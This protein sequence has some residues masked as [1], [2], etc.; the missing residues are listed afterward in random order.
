[1]ASETE[2]LKLA[3]LAYEAATEPEVWPAFLKGYAEATGA[4]MAFLQSHDLGR[5][6]ST[7]LAAFGVHSHFRQS[8]NEHYSK[9]NI[10]RD[11]GS[12]LY[13]AGRVNLGEEMCPRSV[14]ETSEFYNELLRRMG[15]SYSMA[16]V[17]ARDGNLAPT[18]V[19]MR[20]RRGAFGEPERQSAKFLLPHVQRAWAVRERMDRLAAGESVLDTLP[21]GVMFISAA[22]TAIYW[23]RAAD[24]IL[25]ANDGLLLSNGRLSAQD[26]TAAAHIGKAI[27]GALS[28]ERASGPMSVLVP[29]ASLRQDYQVLAAPMLGGLQQFRGSPPGVAVIFIT[30]PERYPA[31]R[32]DLLIRIY[33]LTRTEAA[34]AAKL[35][36]GQSPAQA[37]QSLSM[38]YETARTHLRR[39]FSK[40]ATSRQ[41]ELVL[42]MAQLPQW[43]DSHTRGQGA[44]MARLPEA[45]GNG[46]G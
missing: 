41:S 2:L 46:N 27:A 31:A 3:L 12:A 9:L 21:V 34:L 7:M 18:L 6:V 33:R 8:Y 43:P 30:D 42:R 11:R 44:L 1:M 28:P 32:T 29:R 24:A 26:R 16:G 38:S 22:G 37:A 40:T 39:I 17:I 19:A 20:G 4:D 10:W 14:L 25:G 23:N 45:L 5:R 36:E 35:S 13:R 15:V